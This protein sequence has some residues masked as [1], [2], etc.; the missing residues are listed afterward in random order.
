MRTGLRVV[1][2]L[3]LLLVHGVLLVRRLRVVVRRRVVRGRR[4]VHGRGGGRGRLLR[5]VMRKVRVV[6]CLVR[7]RRVVRRVVRR[8]CRRV[9][10]MRMV[11]STDAGHRCCG[12]RLLVR[13]SN[14]SGL[15]M[16]R[17][18]RS[19]RLVRVPAR[20]GRRGRSL[21]LGRPS[22]LVMSSVQY[23]SIG[24]IDCAACMVR[25]QRRHSRRRAERVVRAQRSDCGRACT[26]R[27]GLVR[28]VV[29]VVV[30]VAVVVAVAA[31]VVVVGAGGIV[32][33][34]LSCRAAHLLRG[35][36]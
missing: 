17:G 21:V 32:V 22:A 25:I 33:A 28:A 26:S 24:V 15:I 35:C 6:R 13:R 5:C 9:G 8:R 34:Q 31:V 19:A 29:V 2:R 7:G 12:G 14:R 20:R 36:C 10:V 18:E 11:R 4:V 27:R 16:V 1:R 23:A 3:L 30:V